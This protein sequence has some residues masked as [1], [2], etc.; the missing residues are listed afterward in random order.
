MLSSRRDHSLTWPDHILRASH[1]H[2]GLSVNLDLGTA[3]FQPLTQYSG[4]DWIRTS[5][6]RTTPRYNH[7]ILE[8]SVRLRIVIFHVDCL[9][10]TLDVSKLL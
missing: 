2:L 1:L 9:Q 6:L 5:Y 10:Q 4:R 8:N 3:V 7:K